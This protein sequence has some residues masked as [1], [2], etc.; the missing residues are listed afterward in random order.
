MTERDPYREFIDQMIQAMHNKIDRDIMG[1]LSKHSGGFLIP[2][3]QL[4]AV[5]TEEDEPM[6][7]LTESVVRGNWAKSN[8]QLRDKLAAQTRECDCPACTNTI[9]NERRMW[10]AIG[11]DVFGKENT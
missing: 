11:I 9:E 2:L 8:E 3:G 10:A 6:T 1:D 4:K 7:E 5:W